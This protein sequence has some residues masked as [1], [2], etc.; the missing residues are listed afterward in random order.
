MAV[1]CCETVGHPHQLNP[2][3]I[4]EFATPAERSD[5]ISFYNIQVYVRGLYLIQN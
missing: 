5:A 1:L 3:K 2:I 4:G